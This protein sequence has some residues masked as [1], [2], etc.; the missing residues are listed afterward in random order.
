MP[1]AG[2]RRP[3]PAQMAAMTGYI[4]RAFER[5]D[6]SVKPDPGRMT[7]HRLNRSEYTNTIRDL[8]G[9]RFRAER[10]FPADDPADGFDNIGDVLTVSP[11]LME[12]YL[13]AAERIARLGARDRELPAKP[14]EIGYL[15]REQ[16]IRRTDRSTI[17]AEHRVEFAGEYI[18]RFGLP[19]ERPP[20]EGFE[21]APVTLGFW[22]D[23][24]LLATQT[25]ETKP[26]GLVYFNPYSEEEFR[27]YL[28]E[29]DHV[30]RA[31]FIDDAF[32]KML[33]RTRSYSR[34]KNKFL[35]AIIFVGPFAVDDREGDAGRRSSPAT[36]NRAAR[37]SR[38]SST[39]LARRAYRRPPTR[40]E[41]D[42]LLRFVDLAKANGQSAEQGVQLAIQAMLVSPNFLFRIERDPDPRDP[43][44]VHEVSP[45][46][47]ASRV[48][49]FLWSS[50]P[51]DELLALAESGKL[52]DPRVLEAQ[53]ESDARRSARVRVCRELRRPVARDAQPRRREAGSGQVQGMDSRAARGDEEPR[54]R[55][56]SSTCCARTVRSAIS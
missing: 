26:S 29:G 49:Y 48:S 14:L 30:F 54:R 51:D 46:E 11:L 17:E 43:A 8:L 2:T 18:V 19:G 47:L 33:P 35:D 13:S 36:R 37:A 6:A 7:A 16:R 53:V 21:A 23:G 34:Q 3:D 41:V 4:E 50:M 39:D 31:G 56:S 38:R 44:L 1:P 24:T 22:M 45:F 12:R 15:A 52:R 10:D 9:I 55:C 27:L 32:V 28:P 20:I 42:S 25:V 5:A 40:G